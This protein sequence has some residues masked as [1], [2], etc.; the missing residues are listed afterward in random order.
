MKTKLF[1][2]L[3]ATLLFS[4]AIMAQF[5]IGIKG[6][7]NITKI[8]GVS[9]KD[10][11]KYGY[12]IGGFAEI[13]LGHKFGIQPEVLFSQYSSSID[14]NYKH[15]YQNVFNS[16]QSSVKLNYLSIP[17]LL[18]YKVIGNFLT[19]QAGPQFSVLVNQDKTLLQ[20]GGEAFKKGDF[21][22]VGGAQLK[23]SAIRITGRYVVGLNNINDIDNQDQWKSQGFQVSL[24]LA[25]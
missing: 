23:L 13:G 21:A 9:F 4:Q 14:S 3:L 2:P 11:F 22:L 8:D 10:Q 7:A 16:D 1:L 18:N 15:I 25:L 5:H 17:I 24:G 20:N 6:G 12:H 19:L